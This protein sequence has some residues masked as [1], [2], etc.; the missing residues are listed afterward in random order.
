MSPIP[1]PR[2]E[3]VPPAAPVMANGMSLAAQAAMGASSI[4]AAA[5]VI[6]R[7]LIVPPM[8]EGLTRPNRGTAELRTPLSSLPPVLSPAVSMT[9]QLLLSLERYRAI[10]VAWN[11]CLRVEIPRESG[12]RRRHPPR[13]QPPVASQRLT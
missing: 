1:G 13:Y 8:A 10:R 7:I 3:T 6:T 9:Y 12:D 5:V 4:T 11:P 2:Q